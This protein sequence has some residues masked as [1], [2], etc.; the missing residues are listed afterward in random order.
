MEVGVYVQPRP[1]PAEILCLARAMPR[2]RPRDPQIEIEIPACKAKNHVYRLENVY[3]ILVHTSAL[4][5][6]TYDLFQFCQPRLHLGNL[7]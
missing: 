7:L 4:Q 6:V 5:P 2:S 1:G 3:H